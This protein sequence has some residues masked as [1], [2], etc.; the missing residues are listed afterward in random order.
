MAIIRAQVI[1]QGGTAIPEDRFVN[2]WHFETPL[3]KEAA[4]DNLHPRLTSFYTGEQ[5]LTLKTIDSFLSQ[6]IERTAEIRYYALADP[7]PRVPETRQFTLG[8]YPLGS[9]LDLPEEV[10]CVL[11]LEGAPP[12]TPSRRGRLY[13]GPLNLDARN[14]ANVSTPCRVHAQLRNTLSSAATVMM[15]GNVDG[16]HWVIWSPTTSSATPVATG[17]I[18]DAFDTQRRRGPRPST[19]TTFPVVG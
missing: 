4:A 14:D 9:S 8:A 5:A 1:F 13:L 16:P 17:F 11:S 7:T 3:G 6:F 15:D 10:A 18:D 19:R 2:T 12:V